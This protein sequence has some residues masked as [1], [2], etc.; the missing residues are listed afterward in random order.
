MLP[1]VGTGAIECD[2][3]VGVGAAGVA[4]GAANGATI[5]GAKG[6]DIDAGSGVDRGVGNGAA[7]G[8][9]IGVG[10]EGTLGIVT[11]AVAV[12]MLGGMLLTAAIEEIGVLPLA[13]DKL[14]IL[15]L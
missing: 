8:A 7:S 10:R 4:A 12:A 15:L 13:R 9:G 5:E 2:K 6:A 14:L 1:T 3:C 11:V